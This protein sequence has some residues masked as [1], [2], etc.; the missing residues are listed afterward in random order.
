[1]E[2][3]WRGAAA[4]LAP[5]WPHLEHVGQRGTVDEIKGNQIWGHSTQEPMRKEMK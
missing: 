5:R 1:M 4:Q 2:L 3:G